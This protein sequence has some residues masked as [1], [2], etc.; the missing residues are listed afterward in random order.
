MYALG[1]DLHR[2]E[3][4]TWLGVSKKGR[5][6][7]LTNYRCHRDQLKPDAK[8]RGKDKASEGI[9]NSDAL[10]SDPFPQV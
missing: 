1:Q 6:A 2:E 4:G 9:L 5:L 10:M 3:K 8:T 7:V